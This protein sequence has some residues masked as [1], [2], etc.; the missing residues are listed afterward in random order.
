MADVKKELEKVKD[1]KAEDVL[2]PLFKLPI[3]RIDRETF[4]KKELTGHYHAD[5]IEKAIQH[6]PAYAGIEKEKIDAIAKEVIKF[7][8]AKVTGI[9]VAAGLPGGWAMAATI[10]ADIAQFYTYILRVLQK[11]AYLYGFPSFDFDE[12]TMNDEILSEVMMFMGV[13]FGVK[14]ANDAIDILAKHAARAA[15]K[16]LPQ[17]ALTKG[18]VYPVVKKIAT[19]LGVKM[20]K[21]I[22]AKGVGKLVPVIGGVISGGFTFATFLPSCKKLQSKLQSMSLCDPDFYKDYNPDEDVVEVEAEAI[23]VVD[24]KV[25]II[26]EN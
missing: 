4:L 26:D 12:T 25:D 7:E 18:I 13:M 21:E 16:K 17:K 3:V 14:G 24:D 5:V 2:M 9:S 11:L 10:P 20:T 15:V 1:I 23:E 6:N 22:F 8:T 19:F